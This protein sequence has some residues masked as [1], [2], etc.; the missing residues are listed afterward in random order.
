MFWADEIASA[1][2]ARRPNKE[3][4]RVHD[5]KTPSGRIHV[6]ALRGVVVHDIVAKALRERGVNV[7]YTYGFDD[8]DPMDGFPV[9]LDES[10]RQYMG[11]PLSEI[12][13]P[14]ANFTGS[15]GDYYSAEFKKVFNDLG[16]NPT[17]V[18]SSKMYKA[19]EYNEAI[20]ISLDK[21]SIVRQVYKEVSGAERADDWFA[22]S[23]VC[24][25]CGKIGTTRTHAWDGAQVAFTCEPAMVKWA[26]GCG[27]SGKISPFDGNAK[28]PWKVEW[29]AKWFIYGEDFETA[30]KDHMTKNGSFDVATQIA[31]KVYGIEEPLGR[32]WPYEWL[33]V[34]GRKMSSSKG[35]GVS[36]RD[37]A[38]L[39]PPHLLM[40]FIARVRLNRHLEFSPD[41]NTIPLLYDEYDKAIA[42]YHSD[43]ESDNA[44]ILMYTKTENQV[45]P[46]YVMRFSKVAFL[47][48]MPNVD[49]WKMAEQEKG[50]P[51][52]PEEKDEL[53][54]RITYARKWLADFAPEEM[55][56][57]LQKDA[58]RLD[59]SGKQR[60]FLNDIREY[61]AKDSP[62]GATLHSHIHELR[63]RY[64]LEPV[65]AFGLIYML[66]LG[67]SSGPQA[68]WFLA[69]LDREFVLKRL[70]L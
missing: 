59:V 20:R 18:Y 67:K 41:G 52:A 19:G 70:T 53:T 33:L 60:H 29:A 25:N 68:G 40:F 27:Y 46:R 13:S 37:V 66:F 56:F 64:E 61:I 31:R 58:P 1:V 47:I 42:S 39:L 34:G 24:P 2:V 44:R 8:F 16:I 38:E 45:I 50:A 57:E 69:A 3:L 23:V 49:E 28:L 43:Q 51:L 36:A 6:G 65:E 4:Y 5:Y 10:F 48:Q 15:F 62:D 7:E 35:M 30:G 63:K 32:A 14:D 17:I 11:M 9:Y 26:V 55:K 54:E 12:P 22:I 21:A